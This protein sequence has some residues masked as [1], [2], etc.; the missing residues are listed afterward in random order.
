MRGMVLSHR[1]TLKSIQLLEIVVDERDERY[2]LHNTSRWVTILEALKDLNPE[3]V[4]TISLARACL[5]FGKYR[6]SWVSFTPRNYDQ[7]AST[8][9][10]GITDGRWRRRGLRYSTEPGSLHKA[11]DCMIGSYREVADP[12]EAKKLEAEWSTGNPGNLSWKGQGGFLGE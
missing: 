11:L 10:V 12:V 4:V 8:V 3:A 5:H 6:C 1:K 7:A 9:R 2:I